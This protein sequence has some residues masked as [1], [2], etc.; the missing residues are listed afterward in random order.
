[1][2]GSARRGRLGA[3]A[4]TQ[5]EESGGSLFCRHMMAFHYEGQE[6]QGLMGIDQMVPGVQVYSPF[7]ANANP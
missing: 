6:G 1:M 5:A 3:E 7:S 2:R 4:L